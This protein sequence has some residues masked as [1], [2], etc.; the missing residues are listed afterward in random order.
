MLEWLPNNVN[1]NTTQEYTY[2]KCSYPDV[3]YTEQELINVFEHKIYSYEWN[4]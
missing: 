1:K 3:G 2:Y 4:L